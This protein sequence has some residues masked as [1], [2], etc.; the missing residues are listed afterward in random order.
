VVFLGLLK[1]QGLRQHLIFHFTRWF[2]T[3]SFIEQLGLPGCTD[4]Y[5]LEFSSFK[6][7]RGGV[8]YF[9]KA[10]GVIDCRG[11]FS[12]WVA[13]DNIPH[14]GSGILGFARDPLVITLGLDWWLVWGGRL[15]HTRL[16]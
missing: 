12:H 4:R 13:F 6:F 16:S 9:V 5:E 2:A 10:C 11:D 3:G 15:L 7:F 8:N 1:V 14:V